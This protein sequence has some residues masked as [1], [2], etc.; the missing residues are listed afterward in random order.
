M[1][2]KEKPRDLVKDQEPAVQIRRSW[3]EKNPVLARLPIRVPELPDIEEADLEHAYNQFIEYFFG[4]QSSNLEILAQIPDPDIPDKL[5]S[6]VA[7]RDTQD[8]RV[9]RI[10]LV[11]SDLDFASDQIFIRLSG[12]EFI[13]QC[14]Y[15]LQNP[16]I[17]LL[18]RETSK[19]VQKPYQSELEDRANALAESLALNRPY[20]IHLQQVFAQKRTQMYRTLK[21][22]LSALTSNHKKSNR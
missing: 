3:K 20:S 21:R 9:I 4:Q 1:S 11:G 15:L 14:F 2:K 12:T 22:H 6:L 5:I 19:S 8:P 17:L 16:N 18:A 10:A 13:V 7:Y